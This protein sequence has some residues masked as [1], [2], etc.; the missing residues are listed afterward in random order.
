MYLLQKGFGSFL[1]ILISEFLQSW[2]IHFVSK[3]CEF[4]KKFAKN[5]GNIL[6]NEGIFHLEQNFLC[7]K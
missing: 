2:M 5:F 7:L 4:I 1:I 6:E 3:R